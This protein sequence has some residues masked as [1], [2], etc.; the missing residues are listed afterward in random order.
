MSRTDAPIDDPTARL[1]PAR[2]DEGKRRTTPPR[3]GD[4]LITVLLVLYPALGTVGVIAASLM[5][6][7]VGA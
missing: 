6:S 4:T 7:G 5:F 3:A 2:T 1:E